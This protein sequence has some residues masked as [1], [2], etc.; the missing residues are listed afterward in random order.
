M[1][2]RQARISL[3]IVIFLIPLSMH[4][5]NFVERKLPKRVVKITYLKR[6]ISFSFD[7]HDRVSRILISRFES[8]LESSRAPKENEILPGVGAF[9]IRLGDSADRVV[10]KLGR[11]NYWMKTKYRQRMTYGRKRDVE[12]SL[13]AD[14]DSVTGI[15]V[16]GSQAGTPE[17]ITIGSSEEEVLNAYGDDGKVSKS[18]A[19]VGGLVLGWSGFL[20]LPGLS[21]GFCLWLITSRLPRMKRWKLIPIWIIAS[22]FVMLLVRS[23]PL[24]LLS[25]SLLHE[26]GLRRLISVNMRSITTALVHIAPGVGI[27]IGRI[28]CE[29]RRCRRPWAKHLWSLIGGLA[30]YMAVSLTMTFAN[31][32]SLW[33]IFSRVHY[34][35][36]SLLLPVVMYLSFVVFENMFG[37]APSPKKIG[38]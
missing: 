11:P 35:F 29:I 37:F 9:G 1:T 8:D 2:K 21:L 3:L 20:L 10:E 19:S 24:F 27:I 4:I 22:F 26:V 17:M 25:P 30:F 14:G 18:T 23:V 28:F 12:V 36:L 31:Y 38:D 16:R 7:R 34:F 33:A 5:Y 6:G 13:S 15:S 32:R